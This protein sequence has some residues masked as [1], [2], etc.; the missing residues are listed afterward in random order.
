VQDESKG[1][2]LQKAIGNM[3]TCPFCFNVWS[4]TTL[5]FGYRLAPR[6]TTHVAEVLTVAAVGDVL[7]FGYRNLRET[8]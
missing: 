3:L 7:D 4:A 5:L 1:T 6:L 8:S 2:G